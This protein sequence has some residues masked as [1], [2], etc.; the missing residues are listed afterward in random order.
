MNPTD[1]EL[2]A[3]FDD[4]FGCGMAVGDGSRASL[5]C[6]IAAPTRAAAERILFADNWDQ[7]A[8]GDVPGIAKS[9]RSRFPRPIDEAVLRVLD[10]VRNSWTEL[11]K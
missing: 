2:A 11:V 1:D 8:G 3:W 10:S 9:L 5:R 6:A 7:S 4:Y